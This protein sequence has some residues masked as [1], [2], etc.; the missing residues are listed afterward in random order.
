MSSGQAGDANDM[1]FAP[2]TINDL[3]FVVAVRNEC[4]D[5]LHDNREFSLAD[6]ERWFTVN[7]PEFY[8]IQVK[9]AGTA[10][11]YFRVSNHDART[12][13]V[14]VG[15]DL[16]AAHR[17]KGLAERA[18]RAFL[19]W[20]RARYGLRSVRLEVLSHNARALALYAKLGFSEVG[21]VHRYAVRGGKPV[22]SIVMK[23]EF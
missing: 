17:G 6:A 2:L 3:D 12:R 4:R 21:R 10:V 16:E 11:G 22:D 18:Y 5:F 23:L 13:S 7:K 14:Y 1:S 19:P 15:A 8:V 20:I 9:P